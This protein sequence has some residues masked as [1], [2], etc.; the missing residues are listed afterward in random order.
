[1]GID[2]STLREGLIASAG[3]DESVWVW[4]QR[5]FPTP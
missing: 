2:F 4:D 5:G 1:V 3:W